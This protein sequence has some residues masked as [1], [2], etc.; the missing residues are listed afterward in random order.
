V[1]RA[2]QPFLDDAAA[3]KAVIS[4]DGRYVAFPAFTGEQTNILR[5]DRR[6]GVTITVSL[7][8]NGAAANGGSGQPTISADG[9]AIAFLSM[10]TTLVPRDAISNE[11][12]L[13]RR[14]W[15]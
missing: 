11:E 5:R 7:A 9:L 12:V 6:T 10:A 4:G 1:V 13:L 3:P 8:T 14:Y 2:A 15:R